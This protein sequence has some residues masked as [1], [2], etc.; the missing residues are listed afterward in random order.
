MRIN[1]KTKRKVLFV[2]AA[3]A[4]IGLSK[5]ERKTGYI[6]RIIPKALKD[7][8]RDHLYR[9]V[10]EF[11]QDR[12]VNYLE[13]KDGKITVTLSEDG[14]K[15]ISQYSLDELS[16][17]KP[18]HWDKKWRLVLF[19]IPEKK[20]KGRDALRIKL[21]ELGFHEWQKSAFVYP[22]P[23][24]MEINFIIEVFDLR[25]YVRQAE[26][27]NITNEAELKIKFKLT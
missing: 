5:S 19:D 26:L 17:P 21:K 14:I 6:I 24:V 13:D 12:L 8:D 11:N 3:G 15:N 27:T 1:S 23:C 25:P 9:L 22:Y 4:A 7:I 10:R 16:I 18:N 2:L 20:R